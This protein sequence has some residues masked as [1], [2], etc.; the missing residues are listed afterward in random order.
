MANSHLKPP[1]PVQVGPYAAT[2]RIHRDE[3]GVAWIDDSNVKVVEVIFDHVQGQSPGK[4]QEAHPDLTPSQIYAAIAYY[5]DHQEEVDDLMRQWRST[6]T[7]G[8]ANPE[9]VGWREK[10]RVRAA[11]VKAQKKVEVAA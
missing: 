2:L 11:V 10:M 8:Y 1:L 9:N 7:E 3:R 4:I 6:Y 5:Y